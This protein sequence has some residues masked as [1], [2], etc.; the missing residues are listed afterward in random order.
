LLDYC[1]YC[2]AVIDDYVSVPQPGQPL[3]VVA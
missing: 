3:R 2:A 1:L